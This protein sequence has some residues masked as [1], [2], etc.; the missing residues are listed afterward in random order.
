MS[1]CLDPQQLAGIG[2][3]ALDEVLSGFL[4]LD[5]TETLPPEG[6]EPVAVDAWLVG[7][8][9]LQSGQRSGWVRIALSEPLASRAADRLF[10][11]GIADPTDLIGE[12]TNLVA[13]R[14]ASGLAAHGPVFTLQTPT[15]QRVGIH[16]GHHQ[17]LVRSHWRFW[18]H[19][20]TLDILVTE[21]P[22]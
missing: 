15:V 8:V 13:G 9:S 22:T 21:D 16:P 18:G 6:S 3:Q 2:R 20:L 12:F 11:P 17:G 14:V 5:A 19:P 10:G 1:S 4:S 7:Q